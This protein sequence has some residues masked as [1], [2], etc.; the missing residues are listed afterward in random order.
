MKKFYMPV[1]GLLFVGSVTAQTT[2]RLPLIEGFSS[3][4]CPPCYSWNVAYSP[5]LAN[6]MPN[7]EAAPGVAVLK[8]QMDWPSPGND[9]SNNDEAD[10]RRGF[11]SVT[12]IPDWRIDGDNNDGTQSQIDNYQGMPAELEIEAAYSVTGNTVTV[13]V[14]FTPLVDLGGGSR[15]YIALA[16]KEYTYTGGTNGETEFH[17]VFRKMLPQDAGASLGFLTAGVEQ[18]FQESYTWTTGTPTQSDNVFWDD[19]IEIVVWVQKSNS[20]EVFNAAIASQGTLGIADG[21]QDDFGLALYPNPAN[22]QTSVVFDG[23][24]GEAVSVELYNNLGQVVYTESYATRAGRQRL[25]LNTEAYESGIYFVKVTMGNK[26]ST[27]RLVL[28]K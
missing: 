14:A 8:F 19:Q 10:T 22:A 23:I 21:D 9:P 24:A 1:L 6:N 18:T 17:H 25:M 28:T 11:Y 2:E 7:D 16:N 15:L 3:N 13:D 5:I 4:T 27:N 12:G 26:V 20:K